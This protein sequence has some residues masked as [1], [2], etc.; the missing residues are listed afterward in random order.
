VGSELFRQHRLGRAG[1]SRPVPDYSAAKAALTNYSKGLAQQFARNGLRVVT[2]SP[3]PVATSAWLG[4][5]GVAA[6]TAAIRGGDAATVV[7]EAEEAIPT[8]RFVTPAEVADLVAFLAS[9]RASM[10]TGVDVLIDGG[11]TQTV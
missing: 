6:Q 8:G 7:R 4:P 10:I 1:P 5:D 9:A 11:L 3:G 2:V